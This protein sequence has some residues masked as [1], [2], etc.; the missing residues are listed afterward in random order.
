MNG[1][2][3]GKRGSAVPGALRDLALTLVALLQAVLL[4]VA[5]Q[6]SHRFDMNEAEVGGVRKEV[7]ELRERAARLETQYEE[8]QR[9][10]T[11]I[12]KALNK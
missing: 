7:V 10:L 11:R 8:I 9:S 12:E 5:A 4:F 2:E 3:S 1:Q 6:A